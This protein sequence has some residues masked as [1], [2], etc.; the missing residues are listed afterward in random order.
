MDLLNLLP[1]K[2][3]ACRLIQLNNFILLS[4]YLNTSSSQLSVQSQ[5]AKRRHWHQTGKG[6]GEEWLEEGSQIWPTGRSKR[7]ST[8]PEISNFFGV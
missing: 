8:Q 6:W 2:F 3:S 1:L 4:D 7:N 5:I